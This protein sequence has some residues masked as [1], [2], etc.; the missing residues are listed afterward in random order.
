MRHPRKARSP[1][2][3]VRVGAGALRGTAAGPDGGT[4]S[5]S[6]FLGVPFMAPPVGR[7]RFASPRPHPPWTGIRPCGEHRSAFLQPRRGLPPVTAPAPAGST[8]E[9]A[10]HA[11]VWTPDVAG[12]RP[13]LIYVHGGGWE[14]GTAASPTFD[15]ARLA[16]H[17]DLVVVTFNY[18]LGPFGFGRHEQLTDPVTGLC[19][20]WGLQD[21]IALVEWVRTTIT[22]FGGDPENIT[23]CGTSAGGAAVWQLALLPRLHGA[24]RRIVPISAAHVWTPAYALEP[25]EA[26]TAYEEVAGRLGVDV[27]GLR[28]VDAER[29]LTV[30]QEYFAQVPADGPARSGRWYRGPV[31]DGELI[32]D[33]DAHRPVPDLSA[34]F[35]TTATEGAFYTAA[36]RPRPADDT[37]LRAMVRDLLMKGLAGVP[38]RLVDAAVGHYSACAREA[39]LASDPFS[40]YTE[41]L[42]DAM[43][44]H[45]IVRTAERSARES[46][47]QSFLMHFEYAVHP[48]GFGSPHE[49][50]SPFLF[51]T[52]GI[53]QHREAFGDG[54][55][56]RRVSATL[57]DLVAS[58]AHDGVPRSEHAPRW[59]GF[60][61]DRPSTMLLGS[62]DGPRIGAV[63]K[64]AQLLFWDTAAWHPQ[65]RGRDGLGR[66]P[67]PRW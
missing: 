39:G 63:P 58:F 47:A 51:G 9:D 17:G 64:A 59:P 40:L 48:P 54:P 53:P 18:R 10:V 60:T 20:N 42:G 23:L 34:L 35:V 37:G 15:G 45:Q 32:P 11:N 62:P 66:R 12:R 46:G 50:T 1:E 57:T 67:G 13:V 56:E 36:T 24:I 49:A 26:R 27:P 33:H 38:E 21:Q 2:P 7:L 31:V 52:H 43:F 25:E 61:P 55:L 28:T 4:G 65:R 3:V 6:A 16:A 44:R 5:V 41:I 14:V 22:A 8:S 29:L 30:W 19:A